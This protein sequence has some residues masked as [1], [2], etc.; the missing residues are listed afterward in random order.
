MKNLVFSKQ[1]ERMIELAELRMTGSDVMPKIA[2][3]IF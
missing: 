2:I 1:S 3:T